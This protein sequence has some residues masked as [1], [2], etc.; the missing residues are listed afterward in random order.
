MNKI[1]LASIFLIFI[2]NSFRCTLCLSFEYNKIESKA[3]ENTEEG[4]N[5][6]NNSSVQCHFGGGAGVFNGKTVIDCTDNTV[7]LNFTASLNHTESN[8]TFI[9]ALHTGNNK[10]VAYGCLAENLCPLKNACGKGE[11]KGEWGEVCC[12]NTNLCNGAQSKASLSFYFLFAF[13]LLP[14]L[15]GPLIN[16]YL[17]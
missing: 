14:F 10:D 12:C 13:I 7:C 16:K 6:N 8:N 5:V 2:N 15:I 3:D 4:K 9:K 1:C 17:C 11:Y